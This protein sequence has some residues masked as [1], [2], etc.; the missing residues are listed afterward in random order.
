VDSTISRLSSLSDNSGT[1]ESYAYLGLGT[2]VKRA[3]PQPNVDLT[4]ITAGGSG[5]GG[6]Q[7]TGLDRFGRVVEQKWYNNTTATTTDDFK[8]GYDRDSNV[9]WR[10]NEINHNFDEL[11]HANGSSN[12]Y[13]NLNQL[14]AFAR[15]T[16][17]AGHDTISSPSHSITYSLDAEGN[18][19]STTTDGGSAVSNTFNKQ[20]EETAAGS[21]TLAFDA[22]GDLTTDDQGHTLVYDAW[23]RLVAV[24]NGATTLVSY[25]YDALGRRIVE[26]P[27]TVNDLYYDAAWQILEERSN[28]VSTATIQYV[29]SPVYVDALVL[30]DRST[31]NNGTLDERLWVQ[32]DANYNVT[33]LVDGSGSVVERY[34]YDPYGKRTILD[35]SFN[36][37]SSSSYAFVNGFQGLRLD[38][39]SGFYYFRFRDFSPTLG[40]FLQA[41]PSGFGA[42]TNFYRALSD[43]P[44]TLVDPYGLMAMG[45]D[46]V[47]EGP[48]VGIGAGS[49]PGGPVAIENWGQYGSGLLAGLGQGLGEFAGDL[50]MLLP[51]HWGEIYQGIKQLI[52]HLWNMEWD[53][54][55]K[56]AFPELYR[57]SKEWNYLSDYER[58]RLAGVAIAKYGAGILTGAGAAKLAGKLWKRIK[59]KCAENLPNCFPPY[60]LVAT[61]AG[62][63]PIASI[64]V[65]DRVWAFNPIEGVWR[66]CTVSETYAGEHDSELVSVTIDGE[67]VEATGHHPFWVVEG[68]SL[69]ARPRPAHIPEAPLNARVAGRWVDS[70]DLQVGD[71]LLL[72]SGRRAPITQLAVRQDR[73]LV[74]NFHVEELN[75]YAVGESQILVHN[76]SGTNATRPTFPNTP[77]GMDNFLGMEGQRIPDLPSTPGRNKVQWK[78]SDQMKITYEQHPYHPNA[79][80]WHKG[81]HYHVD[82]PGTEHRRFLPGEPIPGS[83]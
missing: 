25:K 36:N 10:T 13:D 16:L 62:M 44:T 56:A 58:G 2:V 60:T 27:G 83:R 81:P 79:P 30:R 50:S 47:T 73:L 1:L 76:N 6:D 21:S 8:Y 49:D 9:L 5:D 20:N 54:A 17:N 80:D 38:T 51:W 63:C 70:L 48:F 23:N 4:Y 59:P 15:G 57:L 77:E 65:G 61:E 64:E 55:T 42:G 52:S 78:P 11:Y 28:G 26:N 39:T 82:W 31:A 41:D 67:T 69:E 3:H 12:G 43:A 66:L 22:N 35:A 19:S 71:V 14:V 32:Q 33:A 45:P 53:E 40:R 46:G 74:C 72:R 75:C 68:E 7:Y 34:V 37:R 24:K 29:W 18:F